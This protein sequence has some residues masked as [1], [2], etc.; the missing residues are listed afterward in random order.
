MNEKLESE[1]SFLFFKCTFTQKPRVVI[2][3]PTD[4]LS[5]EPFF[6]WQVPVS[7]KF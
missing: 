6:P 2:F 1:I 7:F 3:Y 5:T 4:N